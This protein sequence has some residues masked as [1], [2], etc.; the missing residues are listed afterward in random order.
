MSP[1]GKLL[2]GIRLR[3][4]ISELKAARRAGMPIEE[5]NSIER[6]PE[7]APGF[8]L[9]KVFEAVEVSPEEYTDFNSLAFQMFGAGELHSG[10][11]ALRKS[12]MASA[13]ESGEGPERGGT[14]DE[15]VL[16]FVDKRG[17]K[18]EP[19]AGSKKKQPL[20]DFES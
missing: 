19:A 14:G 13:A 2:R 15:R 4:N 5:Y 10:A 20:G 17:I 7:F 18:K 8:K 9:H 11:D 6:Q 12:S 1:L 16:A 3:K